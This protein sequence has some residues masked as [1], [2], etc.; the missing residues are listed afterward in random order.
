MIHEALFSGIGKFTLPLL[1]HKRESDEQGKHEKWNTPTHFFI[2][3]LALLTDIGFNSTVIILAF[4]GNFL[5]AAILKSTHY[6][7]AETVPQT[8][9]NL[10]NKIIKAN[11]S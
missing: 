7:G 4:S 10:K 2:T 3:T 9:T 11:Q 8:I 1:Y 5:G 6:V